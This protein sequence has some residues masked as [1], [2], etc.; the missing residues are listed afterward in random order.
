MNRAFSI[1]LLMHYGT[2]DLFAHKLSQGFSFCNFNFSR[3]LKYPHSQPLCISSQTP[4][5]CMSSLP[6]AA[7]HRQGP[8]RGLCTYIFPEVLRQ[9]S[10]SRTGITP[11]NPP[12][13]FQNE[14]QRYPR[15]P[16]PRPMYKLPASHLYNKFRRII[17]IPPS[18]PM[19]LL[20]H[21]NHRDWLCLS[22]MTPTRRRHHSNIYPT[23]DYPRM[24]S[25]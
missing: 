17:A 4:K 15:S 10:C 14:S 21:D 20:R 3:S 23:V 13:P 18:F 7:L 22:S 9:S 24:N 2:T 11:C 1:S 12:Q 5:A 6:A 19:P 25:C 8:A 16:A